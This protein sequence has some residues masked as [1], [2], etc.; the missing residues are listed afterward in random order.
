VLRPGR[1]RGVS[2]EAAGAPQAAPG[3]AGHLSRPALP[4]G[5]SER[6]WPGL[7][8]QLARPG[9]IMVNQAD[10]AEAA[11]KRG[12]MAISIG[13][14]SPQGNQRQQVRRGRADAGRY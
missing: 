14:G 7:D 3:P 10:D 5:S 9:R 6:L 11:L 12:H 13:A 4:I 2:H 8:R 1:R